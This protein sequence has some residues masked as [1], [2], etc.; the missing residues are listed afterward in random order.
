M[1]AL[2]R[3]TFLRRIKHL[4]V[5]SLKVL[6]NAQVNFNIRQILGLIGE[7]STSSLLY[8]TQKTLQHREFSCYKI[9]FHCDF[10]FHG[11]ARSDKKTVISNRD[12]VKFSSSCNSKKIATFSLQYFNIRKHSLETRESRNKAVNLLSNSWLIQYNFY[13]L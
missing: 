11:P 12:P 3:V 8:A 13:F 10:I 9:I 6:H 7:I 2:T 4:E 1:K 5:R